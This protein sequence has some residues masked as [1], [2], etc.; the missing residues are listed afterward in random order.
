MKRRYK[1]LLIIVI[2]ALLTFLINFTVVEN[3]INIVAL[4]D[5]VALGM[6]SYNV[7][8]YSY[9]DYLMEYFDKKNKLGK[10]NNEFSIQHL[11]IEELND[12]LEDNKS[13]ARSK[14]PIKQ[15]IAKADTL[16]IGIGMD[17][18]IDLSIKKRINE[19]KIAT[20]LNEYAKLLRNIRTYYDK[21]IIVISLYP[22][23]DFDK[24]LVYEINREIE[25]IVV[26]NKAKFLDITA[27]ALNAEYYSEETSYYMNYK[28][29]KAIYNQL[30]KIN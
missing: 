2:G 13:G 26:D 28:G 5:G 30:L 10:Y 8:G 9:N 17:E 16:T 7:V 29:H 14:Q 27:L 20:F 25:K 12:L 1:L 19:D 18:F 3:K 6:T 11:S 15:I 23:Y 21:T 4:G 22:A 24:N